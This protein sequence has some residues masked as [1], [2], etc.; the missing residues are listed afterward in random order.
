MFTATV[1]PTANQTPD[2]TQPGT[3]AVNGSINNNGH[4]I[5]GASASSAGFDSDSQSR[6]ARW[7][8]FTVPQGG[9]IVGLRLKFDWSISG[10]AGAGAS[11]TEGAANASASVSIEYSLN[12][13]GNW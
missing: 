4:T 6:S 7:F 2:A 11:G 12:S 8:N 10:D 13:G 3:L 1:N 9:Q 5:S